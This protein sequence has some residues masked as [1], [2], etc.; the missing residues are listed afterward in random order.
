MLHIN[1]AAIHKHNDYW[2]EPEKFNPDNWIVKGFEQKMYVEDYGRMF[3]LICLMA[4]LFK[5]YEIDLVDMET[6]LTILFSYICIF[7]YLLFSNY[8]NSFPLI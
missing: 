5:K 2:E 4:L 1:P 6:P 3:E 8:V 7:I